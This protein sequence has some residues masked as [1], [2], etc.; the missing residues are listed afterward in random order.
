MFKILIKGGGDI[1]E[2]ERCER[3][4]FYMR[5]QGDNLNE[6]ENQKEDVMKKKENIFKWLS[7]FLGI[8]ALMGFGFS[9]A[10][11]DVSSIG[12]A[13]VAQDVERDY[14]E[15][16]WGTLS[17]VTFPIT[18]HAFQG[19]NAAE[20]AKRG[21]S[22]GNVYCTA[23]CT[24]DAAVHLP[25]GARIYF[26]ELSAYDAG[27]GTV[28][29]NLDRCPDNSNFCTLLRGVSSVGTGGYQYVGGTLN[30]T[31]DNFNNSYLMEAFLSAGSSYR[32][33]TARVYYQLQVSPKPLSNT[34]WD[35]PYSHPYHQ[36]VEALVRSG[37]T[38]GCGGGAYCPDAPLT[39][40]Q[41]AVFLSKALG[42]HWPL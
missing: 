2:R 6:L 1:S 31:V 37:I 12:D 21:G 27:L 17:G 40:G 13:E 28:T 8:I 22:G 26:L 38:A 42:L 25:T 19:W 7:V 32:L 39:R 35:V 9:P 29:L 30:H 14:D 20:D 11:G 36:Y 3:R 23:S 34:F 4:H 16:D 33:I 41:M 24:L 18:A 15:L 5:W 10:L